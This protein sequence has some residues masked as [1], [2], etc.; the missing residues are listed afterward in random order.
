MEFNVTAS[1]G[2]S[3]GEQ[4]PKLNEVCRIYLDEFI[5]ENSPF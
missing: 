1:Y 5:L 4:A 2:V 3:L